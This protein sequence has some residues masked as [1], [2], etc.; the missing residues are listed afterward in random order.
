MVDNTKNSKKQE[1]QAN[2]AAGQQQQP[3][4]ASQDDTK[5]F[6]RISETFSITDIRTVYAF[7][8]LIGGGHFGSVRLAHRITDP[9][10]KYAVKSILKENIKKDVKLLEEELAILAQ[11]DHPNIIKFHETY[12]D[13]RYVHIVMELSEGGELFEKIVEMHKFNEKQAASLMR[14]ILSAVK[15]LHE[16][17]ICHRDLKPENFLFS[18]KSEDPEI[19]LIDFGLSKRFGNIQELD[20]SEKMHTIVGTPYYVAPEVLRGNYDFACDIWSLGVILFILLCGY[21]PFEGDNN[22]EIFKNVLKQNLEFDPSDWSEISNEA[23]DLISKML[24]KDPTQRISAEGALSH[25]WFQMSQTTSFSFDSKIIQRIKEFRAPQRLQVEALTFLVNNVTKEIDFKTLRD[26]FRVLDKKN[27]G[28][29][30]VNEIKEAFKGSNFSQE[31]LNDIFKNIDLNH[32]GEI[33]YSEFLAATVDKKKALT[34]QNLWFAFH[35][36]DV[37]NSGYI[38]ERGLE[39]V[40]H[41]E[42]R[43][44]NKEQIHEIMLQADQENKGRVSF[45]DFTKIM[46]QVIDSSH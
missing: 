17:G 5:L 22:K 2:G 24:I 7:E 18:D 33:N 12:I 41:R 44:I 46:K 11:V 14:K 1:L 21:P 42:G 36:F 19:K 38:T 4:Q 39:E 20:P 31:D 3:L 25:P 10:I 37:D 26:A 30:T 6:E 23:K 34:L 29:L 9:Q 43:Q 40:F 15:H 8:K 28:L 32:D 35:H 27:T 45:D 16:H 13:Y